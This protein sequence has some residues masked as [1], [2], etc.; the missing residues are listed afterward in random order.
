MAYPSAADLYE[1]VY[2]GGWEPWIVYEQNG[3]N[4]GYD[5]YTNG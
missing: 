5:G 1:K 2:A 3:K 4:D